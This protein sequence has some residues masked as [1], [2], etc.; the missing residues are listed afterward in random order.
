MSRMGGRSY[1]SYPDALNSRPTFGQWF[2]G[3]WID[4][5]TMAAL[6]AIGLG[7]RAPFVW[8]QPHAKFIYRST[9]QIQLRAAPSQSHSKTAR[10]CSQSSRIQ[11]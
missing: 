10:S 6:G 9:M 1:G 3:V 2:K 4:I 8:A 7:V 11:W 5:L